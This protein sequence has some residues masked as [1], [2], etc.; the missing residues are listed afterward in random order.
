FRSLEL[1]RERDSMLEGV[2]TARQR[3]GDLPLELE[4]AGHLR[5]R[6]DTEIVAAP[7]RADLVADALEPLLLGLAQT[8]RRVGGLLRRLELCPRTLQSHRLDTFEANDLVPDV[9]ELLADLAHAALDVAP[10]HRRA[11]DKDLGSRLELR[12]L[13]LKP[14]LLLRKLADLLADVEDDTAPALG[15]QAEPHQT[16]HTDPRDL[17]R[18]VE[19]VHE[20]L[21]PVGDG[22]GGIEQPAGQRRDLGGVRPDPPLHRLERLNEPVCA[23]RGAIHRGERIADR[24]FDVIP[25]LLSVVSDRRPP[26]FHSGR[27]AGDLLLQLA[28]QDTLGVEKAVLLDER[29]DLLLDAFLERESGAPE[30]AEPAYRIVQRPGERHRRALETA[31]HRCH[32]R[33]ELDRVHERLAGDALVGEQLGDRELD[34]LLAEQRRPLHSGDEGVNLLEGEPRSTR[35]GPPHRLEALG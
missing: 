28:D 21:S 22:R 34:L 18:R 25:R 35:V 27:D 3:S 13:L 29:T 17:P 1:L 15:V 4:R 24:D 14:R 33:G 8:A 20:G 5:S 12:E 7:K 32:V 16:S 19:D 23:G 11:A 26:A 31:E 10:H 2:V 30:V 9:V 6:E